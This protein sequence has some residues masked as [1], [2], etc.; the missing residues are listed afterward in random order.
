MSSP[1][2]SFHGFIII[3]INTF[4]NSFYT[5]LHVFCFSIKKKAAPKDCLIHFIR[6]LSRA[7]RRHR[8]LF[9]LEVGP[10]KPAYIYPSYLLASGLTG[11]LA[12]AAEGLSTAP[13]AAHRIFLFLR[14]ILSPLF[15]SAIVSHAFAA[16]LTKIPVV[17][18]LPPGLQM[19]A[20]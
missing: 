7:D 6:F 16:F 12:A 5:Y 14:S 15:M 13:P 1:F 10:H 8:L 19:V 4:V 11:S 18:N 20:K 9:R 3:R 2:F 17:C